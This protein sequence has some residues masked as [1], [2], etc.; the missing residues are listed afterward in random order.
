VSAKPW[1]SFRA[2][3]A[4]MDGDWFPCFE[5]DG[6]EVVATSLIAAPE[7]VE[8]LLAL[9]SAGERRRASRFVFE[10]DRRRFIIGRARL[11]HLLGVKLG[12]PPD[13][14]EFAYGAQGKP[15]LAPKFAPANLHFNVSHSRDVGV[16]AL[17]SGLPIGVDVEA[18]DPVP[19]ADLI[20]ERF[21]SQRENEVYQTLD[22]A[23]KPLGFFNC[24]TRKESFVKAIGEGLTHPLDRFD[25]SLAPGELARILRV[26]DTPGDQCGWHMASFSPA[27][28][29][30]AAIV[31]ENS[32]S[33][34]DGDLRPPC[35][36][37]ADRQAPVAVSSI[38]FA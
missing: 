27:A 3:N 12:V 29:F 15:T 23:D 28:G 11:R 26:D 9:L 7:V 18:I 24:W 37:G 13:S 5:N 8:T 20:A 31:M 22:A 35:M 14:V 32:A 33:T 10:R 1:H 25:V 36:I 4:L 19:D 16:Y 34:Q 38:G 21:F 6:I 30:V 17:A 2:P